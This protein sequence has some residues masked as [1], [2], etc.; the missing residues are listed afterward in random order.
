MC[1]NRGADHVRGAGYCAELRDVAVQFLID[2]GRAVQS[3]AGQRAALP[4]WARALCLKAEY[5][6]A[7]SLLR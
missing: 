7:N 4:L 5:L 1:G 2:H 6:A 3:R